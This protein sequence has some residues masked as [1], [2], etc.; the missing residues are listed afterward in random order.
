M[1]RQLRTEF[2]GALYH[3]Y[4]RGT[5]KKSIFL[6]NADRLKFLNT[7]NKVIRQ[8]NYL[9]HGYC[10][11]STHYHLIL[12]TPDG[13]ISRGMHLLHSTYAQYFNKRH[14]FVGHVFQGRF[15]SILVQRELY[16]L[17]LCRYI[18][19]NPLR[20]GLVKHPGEYIWSSFNEMAGIVRQEDS[21]LSTEWVLSRFGTELDEARKNYIHFILEGIDKPSPFSHT[22]GKIFLG[23][24]EFLSSLENILKPVINKKSIPRE[25]RYAYRPTLSEVFKHSDCFTKEFRNK[26]IFHAYS[27]LGYRQVD[28]ARQINLHEIT[29]NRII[30]A[31][32]SKQN[33]E[34]LSLTPN[35]K[36]AKF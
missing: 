25:Q 34:Y 4:S 35:V 6:E 19:L 29:V 31:E 23:N 17:E 15:H 10:I 11:M 9:C 8:Y 1:T 26:V 28:I 18:V 30:K 16:L 7:L 13:N 36:N 20:A 14:D 21:I 27:A 5:G 12:E 2:P 3:V 33:I 32:H 24:K 22:V